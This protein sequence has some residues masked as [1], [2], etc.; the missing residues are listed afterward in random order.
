MVGLKGQIAGSH[1]LG[2]HIPRTP[3]QGLVKKSYYINKVLLCEGIGL[4]FYMCQGV[5][6]KMAYAKGNFW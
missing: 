2:Q 5:V 3:E 1:W 4:P 6:R